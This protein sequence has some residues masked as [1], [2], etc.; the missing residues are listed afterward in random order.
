M[1]IIA[2]AEQR[3]NRFKR[4]AFEVI[5]GAKSIADQLSAEVIALVVGGEVSSIAAEAGG[6]VRQK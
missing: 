2:F 5:R 4:T 3:N 6:T 1:K